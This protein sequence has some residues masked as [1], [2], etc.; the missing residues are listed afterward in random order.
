MR[1]LSSVLEEYERKRN[2]VTTPEPPGSKPGKTHSNTR[3]FLVQKHRASH[4][5]YDFRLE[6]ENGVLKSWAIPKGPSLDPQI[7]RLAVL[8]E[9]HPFDYLLFEGTIPKGNY[10][11]GTVIV[12]DHGTYDTE[13]PLKEQFQNG[14]ISVELH[15]Q[16]LRGKF[17]LVRTR[18]E[19]QWLFIKANDKFAST[20]D[21]TVTSPFSVISGLSITDQSQD[22]NSHKVPKMEQTHSTAKARSNSIMKNKSIRKLT[23]N[24]VK[25]SHRKLPSIIKPM[26]AL[27]IA[28]AFNSK[29]WV[30][31]I[32]WDGVRA[33]IFKENEKIR[34]QSRKGNEITYKY[35]EIVKSLENALTDSTESTIMDGEI[36]V[37][38]EKG[39]PN[40]Q[41]HQRRM[42]IESSKEIEILAKEIPATY[43]VFD[44]LYY[45]GKDLKMHSYLERR[46]ILTK[47]LRKDE[48]IKI[49]DYIEENGLELLKQTKQFNLEGIVAKRKSSIYKEGVRS[50]DWLKIKNV[51]TQDC[52]IIGYTKGLGNRQR[53]FGSLLLAV[54]DTQKTK[55]RFVGHTGSGFDLETLKII[56]SKLRKIQAKAMPIDYLPYRNRETAWVKPMLIAEVKFSGWTEEGIMR[57]PIFLRLR[58]D[59]E[60]KECVIEADQP[61][62]LENNLTN[63]EK[64]HQEPISK[65]S[66]FSN[67]DKVYWPATADHGEITKGDLINYYESVS[68]LILPHLKDRP[69]SLSRYPDGILGKSF[70]QKDWEQSKPEYVKTARVYSEH[71]GEVIN[72]LV[73]NNVDSLMWIVNLGAIEMHPWYSRI[74]DFDSCDSSSLLYQEKCGLN[75]P[76]F[77]V[78]D[79]DPYIYS[80][81]EKEGQEPEYNVKGFKAVVEVAYGLNDLLAEI[82]IR[83]FVKTSG[84][85]GLHVYVPITPRYTYEQ[86]R[87]F[88]EIV[89]K[90]MITRFPRKI[91]LEWD[92]IKRKGKVF[93]DYNQNSRGKTIASVYSVRP[94]VSATVSMPIT[95]DKLDEIKPTDFTIETV[96]DVAQGKKDLWEAVLIDKQDVSKILSKVKEIST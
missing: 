2:F 34:I 93:F 53:Y 12:W 56:Y 21:L 23:S 35:P 17:S 43:Y 9:D 79:L 8:T 70:Y 20:E 84:K 45:N 25:A 39:L 66:E 38:D 19:N 69:L 61:A 59:K 60:P 73:C 22:L 13:G 14:K 52:V 32:K 16:K 90:L 72:Y 94:T 71:R 51:K 40:F 96:L 76:D 3:A 89:G 67:L 57:A 85:T 44:I 49:S 88:A 82:N 63:Y 65:R 33:I 77:I 15:G 68:H 78:F 86:T 24:T 5:H 42:N 55:F 80:G 26:L 91:T 48:R 50:Q 10:G 18:N 11:T 54:Y 41:G 83:S 36:V 95:S 81:A 62:V 37:L 87:T 46:R 29:D 58:D 4:L 64:P 47:I 7:K 75:F 28:K 30:F 74:K 92:T 31:E 1:K 6:D 27:P